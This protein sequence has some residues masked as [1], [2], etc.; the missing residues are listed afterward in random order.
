MRALLL[1]L[2]PCASHAKQ[3]PWASRVL[4][5]APASAADAP[6]LHLPIVN[7]GLPKSG[8]SSVE[9]YFLCG[10]N[11]TL[12][13][14]HWNCATMLSASQLDGVPHIYQ[15]SPTVFQVPCGDCVKKNVDAGREALAGC[16]G[17]DVW[18]QLDV[19]SRP[20]GASCYLPQVTD[21]EALHAQYPNATFTL[22]TRPAANWLASVSGWVLKGSPE[23]R[24]RMS[25]CGLPGLG[26]NASDD[27][28][29]A[30]YTNH[31]HAVRA[32]VAAHP[33]HALIEFDLEKSSAGD[34]L[35]QATGYP[36]S[37]WGKS[38]CKKSCH[39]WAEVAAVSKA[40]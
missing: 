29:K 19:Q 34:A 31:T 2:L 9:D 39:E 15:M 13:V 24:D 5:P 14:S 30:F 7:V 36:A 40:Y 33:S 12:N 22:P 4:A 11:G 18:A 1:L 23:M 21:L 8:S 32:F 25:A 35:E 20:D 38:N 3:D 6:T 17:Y 10:G 37:C 16:G 28:F 27:A 26:V